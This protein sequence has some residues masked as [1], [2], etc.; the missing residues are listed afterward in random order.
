MISKLK[1][2]ALPV[3]IFIASLVI[4]HNLIPKYHPFGGLRIPQNE[5]II[6]NKAKIIL[7]NNQIAYDQSKLKSEFKT[8]KALA[9]WLNSEYP[10]DESNKI[11]NELGSV[12]YWDI[13]QSV[14]KKDSSI[15][16][17]T[18]SEDKDIFEKKNVQL[19]ILSNGKLVYFN[20][21]LP[22][23][24]IEISLNEV[25]A[26]NVAISFVQN[27]RR[28]LI[29][30]DDSISVK[31][32]Y[33]SD[34]FVFT[35]VEIINKFGRNEFVFSW[36]NKDQYKI[37]RRLKVKVV[38][39]KISDF[40][41]EEIIPEEYKN[42]ETDIF[43]IVTTIGFILLIII[44]ILIVGYKRF[45]AY[46][47][48]FKQAII[49]GIIVLL[50]FVIKE[51]LEFINIVKIDIV[52]GLIFG[53]VFIAGAAIILWAV[54]ETI[55]REIWNEK[56]LSIDLIYHRKFGH[57]FIGKS[58]LNGISFA[59]ALSAL[60][61]VLLYII[62]KSFNI[63]FAGDSLTSQSYINAEIPPLNVLFGIFNSYGMLAVSFFMFLAAGIKR[64][65]SNDIVFIFSAGLLWALFISSGVNPLTAGLP[66]NLVFGLLLTFILVKYDLLTTFISFLLFKYYVK[67]S[68]LSF[69]QNDYYLLQWYWI[70]GISITA[71]ILS[72]ISIL[73]KDKFTDYDSIT[74]KFVENITERQRLQKELDVAR[75]VQMS[76]LP[77]ENPIIEGLDIASTCIPAFEVGGDYYDFIRLGE[78]K[79]GI[80]IG[81]VSGKGTQAA[82]YMTLTK[83]FLKA[84]AK[85]SDS[86]SQ[87]LIKMNELFYENVERGRF[88]SMI[89]AIV[90][91][92][93]GFIRIAGAGHNPVIY[94]DQDG[95]INL[96]SPKGLALG[97]E[98]G[99]IFNRVISEHEEK[100]EPG[101]VFLFYTDGFTEAV[102]K[103]GDE[104]GLDR[105]F[106]VSENYHSSTSQIIQDKM[107]EDINKFIGKAK[108][109]DDMTMVVLK[110]K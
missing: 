28:D 70:I 57:S 13:T 96:I 55:F 43:E 77:K 37:E 11:I 48:G 79:L 21:E 64:Y 53:G 91:L 82:F 110:I 8:N 20:I 32:N 23:S 68:E 67:A 108:Q 9:L 17:S 38:S 74:P 69:L 46:E 1:P 100:L 109:H 76:F 81:D 63:S 61:F 4:I 93:K 59:A 25:V 5:D 89:Y 42:P 12:Y 41:I 85:Q 60:F 90:D 49:F 73:K 33:S 97:L 87:V 27:V 44:S 72:I 62:S 80:I 95:A 58:I 84:L 51:L 39:D 71:I 65:I 29:L 104:Y 7:K 15:T 54:S 45:R 56:F 86:P 75:H 106:A 22:D 52:F 18:S 92:E 16:I 14:D 40:S 2:I 99:T 101:K 88:I 50:S 94:R 36:K 35:D 34:L 47:V 103:K 31:N 66:I 30:S 102:N 98:K 83:G 105:M 19:K 107:I 6:L 26:K 3:I 24:S 78:K 10:L